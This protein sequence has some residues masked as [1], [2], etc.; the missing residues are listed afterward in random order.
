MTF[1]GKKPS[2]AAR[3]TAVAGLLSL[4]LLLSSVQAVWPAGPGIVIYRVGDGGQEALTF[5]KQYLET[6]GY[7]V[8]LYQGESAIEK[9]VEKANVINRSGARLFLAIEATAGDTNHVMVARTQTRKGDGR[10][11]T[12]NEIPEQFAGESRILADAIA[13]AFDVRSKQMPLFPLLGITMPGIFMKISWADK[14]IPDL[15]K[16]LHSGLEKYLRKG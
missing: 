16:R 3:F 5:V 13:G 11:L 7:Q 4:L 15:A 12:I 9:H 2:F 6:K 8:S 10:F 14:D 1:C